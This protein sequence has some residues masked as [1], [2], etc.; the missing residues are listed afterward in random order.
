MS[1]KLSLHRISVALLLMLSLAVPAGCA[2]KQSEPAAP[3]PAQTPAAVETPGAAEPQSA[4]DGADEPQPPQ[5]D[6]I[7]V[8][9]V[10]ALLEAIAPGAKIV[11]EPGRYDLT[12]FL[13]DY[14]NAQ[15][16]DAWDEAHPYVKLGLVYDGAEITLKDV[17]GLSITGGA[18]DP[19]ETEIVT[20]PRYAAVLNFENCSDIQLACLTMGHTDTGEC[21]GNVL[22][23]DSCH[24]VYL[25]TMDLYGC[26]VFGLCAVN[27]CGG[28]YVSNS[29]IRDCEYGALYLED[30]A[31]DFT[32]TACS[33]S[34]CGWGGSYEANRASR[35]SFVGCSFDDG[36]TTSWYFHNDASFENCVWGEI[37]SYPDREM[38]LEESHG[39]N[40]EEMELL[41]FEEMNGHTNWIGFSV[42]DPESGATEYPGLMG[43]DTM[44]SLI[45]TFDL[46]EDGTGHLLL[47]S[48][49]MD[50]HWEPMDGG[51]F[52]QTDEENIYLNLCRMPSL[53]GDYS[54]WLMMRRGN[55]LIWFY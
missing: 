33:F 43:Q 3:E 13:Q 18:D 19:A 55:R 22:D 53:Y 2:Q 8:D 41:P 20:Q 27:G 38:T 32:F 17:D 49:S 4:A 50:V 37:L 28:I 40:Y 16:Q 46:N 11:L 39:F 34:G 31:G 12:D 25:R 44:P 35:L 30:C 36:A 15:D 52:L 45:A 24:D 51:L 6:S 10:E 47:G 21:S 26:G 1:K 7:R 5:D 54:E 23:F 9:S 48:E 29:T 42:V 14:P